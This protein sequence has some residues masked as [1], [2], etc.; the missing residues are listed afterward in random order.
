VARAEEVTLRRLVD[1]VEWALETESPTPPEA[2]GR[3]VLPPAAAEVQMCARGLDAEIVFYGPASVVTLLWGVVRAFTPPHEPPWRGLERLL[4]HVKAQWEG[5][6]RHRDPI[7]ERDGWRCAVPACTARSSLHDH[8][9][10]Y[11]SRGGHNHQDNRVAIC[12]THHLRGIHRFKVRVS[13]QAP[14]DLTWE[15]GCRT[16]RPP[17]FRTHGDRYLPPARL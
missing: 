17:L 11:R 16:A 1:M 4:L 15:M 8:H 5:Q 13:G 6:P 2:E 7:F 9:V 14:D 12:A 10:V 3:L